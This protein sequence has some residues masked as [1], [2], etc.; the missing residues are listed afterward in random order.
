MRSNKEQLDIILQRKKA[1]EF[2][3]AK[4]RKQM[5]SSLCVVLCLCVVFAVALVLR[6]GN[7]D[8][9]KAPTFFESDKS[10]NVMA[11]DTNQN[12]GGSNNMMDESNRNELVTDTPNTPPIAPD[13]FEGDADEN[14]PA[15]DG[16]TANNGDAAESMFEAEASIDDAWSEIGEEQSEDEGEEGTVI[17]PS[18]SATGIYADFFAIDCGEQAAA[19]QKELAAFE[20]NISYLEGR[21]N[22]GLAMAWMLHIKG[23][24]SYFHTAIQFPEGQEF[25]VDGTGG[26]FKDGMYYCVLNYWQ[27]IQYATNGCKCLFVG[28]GLGNDEEM[29]V[30]DKHGIETYCQLYGDMLVAEIATP[31]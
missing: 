19:F 31:Y 23:E 28:S 15:E 3:R 14:V 26:Y 5:Y 29:S 24:D 25:V 16:N 11:G 22:M 2:A 8:E 10:E 21:E 4:R 18:Y 13:D 9:E 30:D 20:D 12:S 1:E 27:V 7:K 17:E 6:S